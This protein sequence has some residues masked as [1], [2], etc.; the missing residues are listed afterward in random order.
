MRL[1]GTTYVLII[2]EP[3]VLK[4]MKSRKVE[5]TSCFNSIFFL[6]IV[7]FGKMGMPFNQ[8]N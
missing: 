4:I 3:F 8:I 6:A 5:H 1:K 2:K 7:L